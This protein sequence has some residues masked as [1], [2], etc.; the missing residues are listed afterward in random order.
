MPERVVIDT[1]PGIDDALA[2]LLAL[3]S[4]ELEVAA[5][6]TVSGNV[7]VETATRNVFTVLSLFPPRPRPPV[8]AGASKPFRK[9]PLHARH[10][11][12]HDGLGGLD[13]CVDADG[14]PRYAS[15]SATP[16]ERSAVDEILHQLSVAP[17][18]TT[19]IALG[20]LTNIA[21]AILKDGKTMAAAKRIVTMG[22]AIGV[23]GNIT[24]AAE[25][26]Y[27]V[28]PEAAG[29]VFRA[30][31]PLTVVPL[32]VTLQVGLTRNM[33]AGAVAS[34][35]TSVCR[36]LSDCTE[37]LFAFAQERQGEPSFFLHDPLAVGVVIEPSFVSGQALNIEIE[38]KGEVTE[39][40]SVAD[41][42]P[43]D[44]QWKKAPNAEVCLQVDAQGFITFFLERVTCP[45]S[46][47]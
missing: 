22:G 20:P 30:G 21:A 37:A 14:R 6:T 9:D 35:E 41:R 44:L 25:F 3:Q 15:P 28:D 31:I 11:H 7:P 32:D 39:G 16:S 2:L 1:D 34:R 10:I 40:M 33:M 19:L 42:R 18:R 5:I 26:N 38:T 23:P 43:I 8:A 13:R 36:F 29:I 47:S 4:P 17:S 24:P 12:G 27:Y 46:S 45:G